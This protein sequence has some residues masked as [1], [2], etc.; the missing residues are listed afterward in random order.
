[1]RAHA[2]GSG[3][4]SPQEQ[5]SSAQNPPGTDFSVPMPSRAKKKAGPAMRKGFLQSQ[6][7]GSL[8][9]EEGSREGGVHQGS[10]GARRNI[11]RK[12]EELVADA[13]PDMGSAQVMS[14]VMQSDCLPPAL[15]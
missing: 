11:D 6:E 3:L 9:G 8:Y 5:E 14:A 7:G 13:D 15:P 12:F 2:G 4:G 10:A 1:M